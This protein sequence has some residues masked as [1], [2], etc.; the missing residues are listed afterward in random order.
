VQ[1]LINLANQQI[2]QA[3]NNNNKHENNDPT[4]HNFQTESNQ[5]PTQNIQLHAQIGTH[6]SGHTA[7]D[8][9]TEDA[10]SEVSPVTM[11]RLEMHN[12]VE[13]IR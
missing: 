7:I 3:L 12:E 2:Y 8:E 9:D 13:Y 1:Q 11:T 5:S 4:N 10:A 6:D